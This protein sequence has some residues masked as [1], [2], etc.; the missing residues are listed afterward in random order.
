MRLIVNKEINAKNTGELFLSLYTQILQNECTKHEDFSELMYSAISNLGYV[1]GSISMRVEPEVRERFL[2]ITQRHVIKKLR[3][4]LD[5]AN[6]V[7]P[8]ITD[9]KGRQV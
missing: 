3:E 6:K 7:S 8:G 4:T 1:F 9:Q 2:D 5:M